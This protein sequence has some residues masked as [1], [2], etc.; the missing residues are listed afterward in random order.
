MLKLRQKL[1]SS[2]PWNCS[3]V[4]RTVRSTSRTSS[5]LLLRNSATTSTIGAIAWR[6][7]RASAG[8]TRRLLSRAKMKP[9]ASTPSSPA[10]RTSP[11]RVI[12][13]NL[14]RVR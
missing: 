13:Q 5:L 8:A 7:A 1:S 14:M 2:S 9:T 4:G 10:R 12:P 3:S 11:A 6:I